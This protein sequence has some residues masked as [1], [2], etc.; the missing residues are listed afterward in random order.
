MVASLPQ[1]TAVMVPP[2]EA[3]ERTNTWSC[4]CRHPEVGC[5]MKVVVVWMMILAPLMGAESLE[6]LRWKKRVL[7]VTGKSDGVEGKLAAGKKGLEE[8]DVLVVW[9]GKSGEGDSEPF[10]REL[11]ERM[12]IRDEVTEVVLLGKDGRTTL[13]WSP[14][15]FS[16]ESL[17]GRI[18]AMPMR[19][20]EMKGE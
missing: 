6:S 18:D 13:R 4:F 15:D 3:V 11:K 12:K 8:R 9:L 14:E 16:L 7:V 20:R 10:I 2:A 17:F 5:E 19:Q 1:L